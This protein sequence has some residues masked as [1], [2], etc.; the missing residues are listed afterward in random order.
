MTR[1]ALCF[2]PSLQAGRADASGVERVPH[3][4]A[5]AG[6]MIL[7]A[8]RPAAERA[9][10]AWARWPCIFVAFELAVECRRG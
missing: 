2:R 1:E 10:D 7:F 9:A 3:M 6:P 5:G 8:R 4:S